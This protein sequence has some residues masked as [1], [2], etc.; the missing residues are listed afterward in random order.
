MEKK[1]CIMPPAVERKKEAKLQPLQHD[2]SNDSLVDPPK[3]SPSFSL[4]NPLGSHSEPARIA[5]QKSLP[6]TNHHHPTPVLVY[7]LPTPVVMLNPYLMPPHF[8]AGMGNA[9]QY[10]PLHLASTLPSLLATTPTTHMCQQYHQPTNQQNLSQFYPTAEEMNNPMPV[11]K[12]PIEQDDST[13]QQNLSQFYP[14]AEEENNSMPVS[15]LPTQEDDYTVFKTE[16]E[17][18]ASAVGEKKKQP[19]SGRNTHQKKK[20]HCTAAHKKTPTFSSVGVGRSKTDRKVEREVEDSYNKKCEYTGCSKYMLLNL[21]GEIEAKFC[22]KHLAETE[23]KKSNGCLHAGCRNLPSFNFEGIFQASF[24]DQHKLKGMVDVLQNS[25]KTEGSNDCHS[26]QT[27]G[28][29]ENAP[30]LVFDGLGSSE[31]EEEEEEKVDWRS[32]WGRQQEM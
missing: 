24:C 15:K 27:K 29:L 13:K 3:R 9:L 11:S 21:D 2:G 17:T 31:E 20:R 30:P 8:T 16:Y 10:Q 7:Q 18:S 32:L 23:D 12:L 25:S 4:Q 26:M 19:S 28:V 14:T 6:N 22:S 5:E 1:D